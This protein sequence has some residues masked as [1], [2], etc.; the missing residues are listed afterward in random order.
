QLWDPR[1]GDRPTEFFN[2]QTMCAHA[3]SRDGRFFAAEMCKVEPKADGEPPDNRLLVLIDLTIGAR[4]E[5]PLPDTMVDTTL[6]FSADGKLLAR[7]SAK[8]HAETAADPSVLSVF[9]SATGR[10]LHQRESVFLFLY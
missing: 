3:S 4:I 9:E 6:H 10:L 5:V 1:T 2:G 8:L 7:M